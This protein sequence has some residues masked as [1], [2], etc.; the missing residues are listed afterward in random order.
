[1]LAT[2]VI[3]GICA[4]RWGR[5][6][7]S[8]RRKSSPPR[9]KFRCRRDRGF[10]LGIPP[11]GTPKYWSVPRGIWAKKNPIARPVDCYLD[12]E[13]RRYFEKIANTLAFWRQKR[14]KPLNSYGFSC[15]LRPELGFVRGSA[16]GEGPGQ[17]PEP[18]PDL[19][20]GNEWGGKDFGW[21]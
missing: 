14:Q 20:I 16:P 12:Y 10:Y 21:K 1:M 6:G 8:Q 11:A 18:P 3:L 4:G 17:L 5:D 19:L 7:S 2:S 15:I 13:R 9:A